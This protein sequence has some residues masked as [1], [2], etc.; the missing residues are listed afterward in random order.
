MQQLGVEYLDLYYLHSPFHDEK[1]LDGTLTA[2]F[3]MI[4]EGK[5][6]CFGLSNFDAR[7]LAAFY[8]SNGPFMKAAQLMLT[9]PDIS[10]DR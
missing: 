10:K 4:L 1:K 8:A 9:L 5:I 2:I 6:K 3:E 7:S